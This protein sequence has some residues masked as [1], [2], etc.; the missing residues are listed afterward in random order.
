MSFKNL[1][2]N[3]KVIK[4]LKKLGIQEPTDI[5]RE[6]IPLILDNKD[7]IAES[8]TGTGK[9]LAFLL[10]LLEKI[11][12]SKSY[13]QGLILTPT[14]EL[15]IQIYNF[16]N[17]LK[18]I[19]NIN[20]LAA[21]GGQD[22]NKQLKK[23]EKGIHLI[24]AT[25][26]RLIDHLK[27]NSINLSKLRTFVLDEAD[28]ML[29][30]GFRNEVEDIMKYAPKKLQ[31]L[32][33]SATMD[34][35]VKKLSYRYMENPSLIYIKKEEVTL[36]N[37]NQ[38]VV[39]TTDRWK[40]DS[41]CTVLDEDNPFLAIIFCRTKRRADALEEILN[42]RKYNCSKIH[43]DVPQNK[44]ERIMKSFREAKIQYLVATDVAA[45]GI[46]V[47]GVTHIYNYDI[48]ENPETYIHRIGRTGRKGEEGYTCLFVAPKDMSTLKE[49]EN[50][51]EFTLPRRDIVRKTYEK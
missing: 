48:P 20:V 45:R 12:S 10:P 33:Y 25:P 38:Q 51:I 5:Q 50:A 47:T 40:A 16:T 14:R 17:H 43:S 21:Y 22:I 8:Q 28:Q 3:E 39:E 29:F 15:A 26:G 49:I 41:L 6:S 11:D 24:I 46:D 42:R 2:L 44:R 9:T 23:S 27:R 18:D 31:V 37:I 1:G 36:K 7:I 30:M 4:E 13:T 35:K 19:Y 34:A 32:C